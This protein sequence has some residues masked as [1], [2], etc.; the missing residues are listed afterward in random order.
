M[1]VMIKLLNHENHYQI[2]KNN[3]K[4]LFVLLF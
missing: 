3:S 1:Y 2:A 4:D